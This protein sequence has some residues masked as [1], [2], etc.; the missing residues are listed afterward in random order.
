M[1]RNFPSEISHKNLILLCYFFYFILKQLTARMC[2]GRSSGLKCG[3]LADVAN[4]VKR[5]GICERQ[6][7]VG[8]VER[9]VTF[10]LRRVSR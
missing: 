6:R 8:L 7:I 4:T 3:P 5:S 1:Q 9:L 10:L 2:E